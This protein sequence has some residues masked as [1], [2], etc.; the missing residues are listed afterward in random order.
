[1][2]GSELQIPA[3]ETPKSHTLR[4]A[5]FNFYEDE[6]LALHGASPL[7]QDTQEID[8]HGFL[9]IPHEKRAQTVTTRRNLGTLGL[10]TMGKKMIVDDYQG[11]QHESYITKTLE[12]IP[13]S[14]IRGAMYKG[15]YTRRRSLDELY[16]QVDN[17]IALHS[18]SLAQ[19]SSD[20]SESHQHTLDIIDNEFDPVDALILAK[21]RDL[22][23][24]IRQSITSATA[25]NLQN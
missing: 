11:N 17:S 10:K 5:I 8:E 9:G 15:I 13:A 1:M 19:P 22:H 23:P 24:E 20:I 25:R 2:A 6:I 18:V 3:I 21:A 16:Y 12:P 7:I 14:F 4:V